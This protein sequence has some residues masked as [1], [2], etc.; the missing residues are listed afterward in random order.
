M[1][2]LPSES[3]TAQ[4]S[5]VVQDCQRDFDRYDSEIRYLSRALDELKK[6][7]AK[8]QNFMDENR[9]IISTLRR[10][11]V[12]VLTQ[13]FEWT[14][15]DGGLAISEKDVIA[16]ALVISQICAGWRS[17]VLSSPKL[18]SS[19]IVEV[20][21]E[22]RGVKSLI[23]LYLSRSRNESLTL[24]ILAKCRWLSEDDDDYNNWPER[25]SNHA[26]TIFR[27]L[28]K[29]SSRWFDISIEMHW[30][31]M[32][33]IPGLGKATFGAL[34]HLNV[35]W[36][37]FSYHDLSSNELIDVL[38]TRSN[39]HTLSLDKFHSA[40]FNHNELGSVK[41]LVLRKNIMESDVVELFHRFPNVEDLQI[42]CA[43]DD[44]YYTVDETSSLPQLTTRFLKQLKL[45]FGCM[46]GSHLVSVLD[47]PCLICLCLNGN[48][49]QDDEYAEAW[50]EN[51]KGMLCRSPDL[52]N[53]ELT[54]EPFERD[55]D[56]LDVLSTTPN[57]THLKI[58]TAPHLITD[59]LL[60][61]L[62]VDPPEDSHVNIL[63][64]L[65][66]LDINF[67]YLVRDYTLPNPELA[68][69]LAL[70][71]QLVIPEDYFPLEWFSF[72]NIPILA[73]FEESMSAQ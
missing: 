49:E 39:L 58:V 70:S 9:S 52:E 10:I 29:E 13:I 14:C 47:L 16:P 18:W 41:N 23:Q 12:E 67:E 30:S 26:R 17:V 44:E 19:L 57:V 68:L 21:N 48:V 34:R 73:L 33:N 42:T 64:R 37:P 25:I 50:L 71:R 2:Y 53:L 3:E 11:P 63:P 56:I 46:I 72:V 59:R 62:M 35:K 5:A 32:E 27:I 31:V 15:I 65:T 38:G 20:T 24:E 7:K 40:F 6:Q 22:R 36:E 45:D 4:I 61:G 43:E 54:G 8:L 60:T 28:L 1:N 55:T 66:H 69:M 51:L